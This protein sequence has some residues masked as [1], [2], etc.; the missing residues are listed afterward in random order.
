MADLLFKRGRYSNLHNVAITDGAVYF[1]TD[2][3]ELYFDEGTTRHRIQ[4][5]MVV[6]TL[7]EVSQKYPLAADKAA[8]D[9]RLIYVT[10]GNILMTYDADDK[11]FVQINAQKTLKALMG[12]PTVTLNGES[13]Q[14]V[15]VTQTFGAGT[16]TV[17]TNF[18]IG[19][20]TPDMVAVKAD[21]DTIIIDVVNNREKA[22]LSAKAATDG[23]SL[24]LVSSRETFDAEGNVT[25]TEQVAK[26]SAT[27]VGKGNYTDV[28]LENGNIVVNTDFD[29][30]LAPNEDGQ[31]SLQIYG[32]DKQTVVKEQNVTLR[33]TLNDGSEALFAKEGADGLTVA[34]DA[35]TTKQVDDKIKGVRDDLDTATEA[36]EEEI[37][38]GLN[39]ADA[40]TFKGTV[41]TK[42]GFNATKVGLPLDG[43]KIGDTYKVAET[44]VYTLSSDSAD[45]FSAMAG[46]MFI[47]TSTSGKE[48]VKADDDNYT[49]ARADVKWT[50]IP[51]GNDS[52]FELWAADGMAFLGADN[53]D[54]SRGQIV[55]GTAIEIVATTAKKATIKHADV[56]HTTSTGTAV[57]ESGINTTSF[58]AVTG[59]TVND[60]GHVT[61]VETSTFSTLGFV[62]E[63]EQVLVVN[64][65]RAAFQAS[66]VYNNDSEVTNFT[67][68]IDSDDLVITKDGED[69]IKIN[70][71]VYNPTTAAEDAATILADFQVVSDVQYD[72]LGHIEAVKTQTLAV[73]ALIPTKLE[74]LVEAADDA[75]SAVLTF[76]E[77]YG[78]ASIDTQLAIESNTLA[79]TSDG[80]ANIAINMVWGSF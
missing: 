39:A 11:T 65:N 77:K 63:A 4:D 40:M 3:H 36:L 18:D 58:T 26:T 44:G 25:A 73:E 33:A 72:T 53:E 80:E 51:S 34:L 54:T 61:A 76:T 55:E 30:T 28:V 13:E 79:I 52:M 12:T 7:A 62:P 56:A 15:T 17:S 2:T 47:A 66:T 29:L 22:E 19:T 6:A 5:T 14:V 46:D 45:I 42:D 16:D 57:T 35:Y 75:K 43:V 78:N 59:V 9:G 68:S 38:Q 10:D 27:I 67:M 32:N 41:A 37:R 48:T 69:G 24:E 64:E 50:Y 23:A 1:T 49:I 74:T 31:L 20:T 70:H 60:Q 8:L 71:P 21:G